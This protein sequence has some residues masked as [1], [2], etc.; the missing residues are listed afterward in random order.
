[1]LIVYFGERWDAPLFDATEVRQ[2]PAPVGQRCLYCGEDISDGDRGFMRPAML[3]G[4]VELLPVHREC[5]LRM[6]LG[7]LDHVEG[8]C[9][10]TGHCNDLRDE[11]GRT[12]RQDALAVWDWAQRGNIP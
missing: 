11:A 10:H 5:E 8:R 1:V 9:Q 6:V 12:L 4:G 2:M 3:A 7:G